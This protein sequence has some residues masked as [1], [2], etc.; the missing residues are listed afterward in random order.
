MSAWH[1]GGLAPGL[2]PQAGGGW[3]RVPPACSPLSCLG[4]RSIRLATKWCSHR[5]WLRLDTRPFASVCRDAGSAL[6][7][8]LAAGFPL[9]R[10]ERLDPRQRA[11]GSVLA[12]GAVQGLHRLL[13][14]ADLTPTLWYGTSFLKYAAGP[15]LV[16]S[17]VPRLVLALVRPRGSPRTE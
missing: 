1:G 9:H 11:A 16:A 13:Q 7:L 10:G 5:A 8:G 12:L 3:P 14:P 15:W 17:L 2:C 6:G 4:R